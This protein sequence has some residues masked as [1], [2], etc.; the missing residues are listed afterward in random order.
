MAGPVSIRLDEGLRRD[1]ETEAAAR[2][3]SLASLIQ[4]ILTNAVSEARRRRMREG[5]ASVA[6]YVASSP[7]AQALFKE[8]GGAHSDQV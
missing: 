8:A 1:L 7:A 4:D 6:A 2:G 5:S 3:M